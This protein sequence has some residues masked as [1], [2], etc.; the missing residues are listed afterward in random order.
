VNHLSEKLDKV[1]TS[2]KPLDSKAMATAQERQN[3][4]TKPQG[5]LGRLEDLSIQIAG[6]KADPAP[7]IVHKAIVTMA[8]DHGVVAEGVSLYPQ[9]VTR[10]M[11]LNFLN[12]G[13]GINV[14]AKHIGAR[15]IIVDMGVNGGFQPMPGLICKMIDFGTKNMAAGAAMTRAQAFDALEAGIDIIEEEA[16]KGLDIV[17][18]GE[19]GIGNTTASSATLAAMSGLPVDKITGRGTGIDDTQLAGKIATIEK[20]LKVNSPDSKDPVDVLAKVGGFEIGGLAG[21]ILAAASKRIPVVIDG[22]I[23]GAAALIAAGLSPK[24]KDYYIASHRSVEPGHNL[25]LDY[26]GLSPLVDLN[27]RLGEGTGAALG[28]FIAEASVKLLNEMATFA[29]A[30]VSEADQ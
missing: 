27:M 19:M 22:F 20:A 25:L 21:V 16:A 11:V 4:L 28:I 26:L 29:E 2:I 6:I 23:S 14:L 1:L 24:V 9:E 17:G 13:A 30:G 10:Q 8:A 3:D 7:V 12:D 18:T 5:S 15:V